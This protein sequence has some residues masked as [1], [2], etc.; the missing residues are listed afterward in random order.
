VHTVLIMGFAALV[1][2]GLHLEAHD[3][4]FPTTPVVGLLV[5]AA[6]IVVLLVASGMSWRW[7]EEPFRQR[8][9]RRFKT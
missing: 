7:V 3:G 1:K 2:R 5:S 4:V 9:V 8:A 6:M